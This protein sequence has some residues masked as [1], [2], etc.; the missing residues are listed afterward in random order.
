MI[1]LEK[2]DKFPVFDAYKIFVFVFLIL[3]CFDFIVRIHFLRVEILVLQFYTFTI[4][5]CGIDSAWYLK[6][7]IYWYS[8]NFFKIWEKLEKIGQKTIKIPNTEIYFRSL[9]V[10]AIQSRVQN[11]LTSYKQRSYSGLV[12]FSKYAH[13]YRVQYTTL[14]MLKIRLLTHTKIKVIIYFSLNIYIYQ[15]HQFEKSLLKIT[16]E[17]NYFSENR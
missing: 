12:I 1:Q 9:V 16:T 13:P 5:R 14:K 17:F 3:S 2:F 4:L 8:Y 10:I 7:V 11:C 15:K 6:Q